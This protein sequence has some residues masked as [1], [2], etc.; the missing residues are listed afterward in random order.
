MQIILS[1]GEVETLYDA[2][3]EEKARKELD[4]LGRGA[5]LRASFIKQDIKELEALKK[6]FEEYIK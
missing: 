2:L 5:S 1:E 3:L 4:L 6:R